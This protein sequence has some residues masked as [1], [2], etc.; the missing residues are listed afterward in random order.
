[1]LTHTAGALPAHIRPLYARMDRSDLPARLR[2]PQP[3]TVLEYARTLS[4]GA[5]AHLAGPNARS[6]D[7]APPRVAL[8]GRIACRFHIT[9]PW[10]DSSEA[11]TKHPTALGR[12]PAR[13]KKNDCE[14][15]SCCNDMFCV[16][17]PAGWLALHEAQQGPHPIPPPPPYTHTRFRH[18]RPGLAAL[19]CLP[20]VGNPKGCSQGAACRCP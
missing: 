13:R 1:M 16:A 6:V 2:H 15:E 10:P 17:G 5:S 11:Q 19:V 3:V 14:T 12:T 8:P 9:A 20:S 18:A 4:T 7:L